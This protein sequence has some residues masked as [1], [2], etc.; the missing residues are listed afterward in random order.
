MKRKRTLIVFVLVVTALV[1]ASGVAAFAHRW[2]LDDAEEVNKL[3]GTLQYSQ[4]W[5]FTLSTSS[6]DQY[7]LLLHPMRFLEETEMELGAKDRVSVSGYKVEDDAIWVSTVTKGSKTY[8]IADPDQIGHYGP[9]SEY[10]P[11][12]NN[13]SSGKRGHGRRQSGGGWGWSEGYGHCW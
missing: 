12:A 11:Y 7:R 10:G 3:D 1:L 2:D 13:R 9:G 6:G 4:T 5:G 8:E